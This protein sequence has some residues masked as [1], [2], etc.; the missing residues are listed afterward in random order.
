L[1]VVIQGIHGFKPPSSCFYGPGR[2]RQR[3]EE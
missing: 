1:T 2:I 3:F